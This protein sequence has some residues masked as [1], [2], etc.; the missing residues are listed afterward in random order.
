MTQRKVKRANSPML[1]EQIAR[2]RELLR[3][4]APETGSAALGAIRQAFPDV[5]LLERVNILAEYHHY[6]PE[7]VPD[8]DAGVPAALAASA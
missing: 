6:A 7:A 5:P 1:D 8:P 4:M 2:M 3:L